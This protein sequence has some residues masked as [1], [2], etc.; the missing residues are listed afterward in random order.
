MPSFTTVNK[1]DENG[2]ISKYDVYKTREEADARIAEVHQI[3]GY[4]DA[5]VVD[6]DATSVNGQLCFQNP[7]HFP[8][9]IINKT[10]SFDQNAFDTDKYNKYMGYLRTERNIRLLATDIVVLPDRW[11]LMGDDTKAAW[12]NYR[13]ALRDLPE[14]TADPTDITWP[15]EP[16]QIEVV[17]TDSDTTVATDSDTTE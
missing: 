8:V 10:V 13:Q 12:A 2:F 3:A 15:E 11:A 17:V 14:N 5:F 16:G 6:N 9:D 7:S 1:V 4:E